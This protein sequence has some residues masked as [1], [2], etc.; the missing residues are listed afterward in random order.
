MTEL[1]RYLFDLQGY[2]VVDNVLDHAQVDQLNQGLDRQ[3]AAIAE[4]DRP[5][6]RFDGLL[7]FGAV[8]LDLIAHPKIV[9]YLTELLGSGFR[10]DHEYVHI[11]R[12]GC[13]QVGNLHGGGTPH[14]PGQ[15]YHVTQGRFYNGLVAVAF[16]LTSVL[17]GE[18]GFGCIPGSH[19]SQFPVPHEL[20]KLSFPHPCLQ[21]VPV[22]IGSAVIF[23]EAL[24][25]GTLQWQGE[26]ERR[27]LFYK[28]SPY[29]SAWMRRYYDSD[30]YPQ[31]TETQRNV[32]KP[33]GVF[34]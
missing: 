27:T 2:L 29:C 22:K 16:N 14:D 15:Y 11:L 31:L 18:G 3:V 4:P 19:K 1:E 28:F 9:P 6:V 7:D 23:T 12:P 25:H 34:P 17:P 10:L 32:L 13:G 20:R 8:F 21:E 26:R 5:V 24:T 30:R 33:P